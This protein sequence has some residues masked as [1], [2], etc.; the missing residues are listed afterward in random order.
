[1][2]DLRFAALPGSIA[3]LL[4]KIHSVLLSPGFAKDT[5]SAS[6]WKRLESSLASISYVIH[7]A[8]EPRCNSHGVYA[9][10]LRLEYAVYDAEDSVDDILFEPARLEVEAIARNLKYQALRCRDEFFSSLRLV[11][12]LDEKPIWIN[13]NLVED[14]DVIAKEMDKYGFIKRETRDELRLSD[15]LPATSLL[16]ETAIYGREEDRSNIV[17]LLLSGDE[18]LDAIALVGTGGL[19]KTTLA[20]LVYNDEKVRAHFELKAWVGVHTDFEVDRITRIILKAPTFCSIEGD[21]SLELLLDKLSASLDGKKFLLVLDDVR[22]EDINKWNDLETSLKSGARGSKII[23]TT[24]SQGVADCLGCSIRYQLNPLTEDSCRSLLAKSAYAGRDRS[25]IAML[26]DIGMKIL[27]TCGGIPL[28]VRVIGGLL[29]F[30]KSREEWCHVLE[31]LR[32]A[33]NHDSISSIVL[34]SYYHLPALLKLC[35]AYCSLFPIDYEFHKEE[36]VLLWMAAGFLQMSSGQSMET[37]GAE[38]VDGL[39]KRSF[40]IPIDNSHFKMHDLIHCFAEDVS[41]ELCLRWESS[42]QAA[43]PQRIRHL[44]LLRNE[45]DIPEMLSVVLHW[46]R[47]RTF[48]LID[49]RSCQISPQALKDIFPRIRRLRVLS[50][51]HFPHAKLPHSI[52]KLKYLHYLDVSHSALASLPESLS[53]LYFLQTLILTN[54]YSLLMLPQG[55][56]KLVNLRK[57][58]IKGAGLMQMPKKMSRLTSLQSLTNFIVGHGGSSIKELGAL[59]NLHGSLSVSGLQNVS[60]PSDASGANLKAMLYL[61]ELE[62]EWSCNN[63]DPATDQKEVL[64]NLKP[65]VELKKLSIRFYG[66]KEFPK[67]LGDSSFSKIISLHLSDCINCKSFPPLGRLSSLEHL[68]I[69]RIG[70]IKS[71]GHEFYGVDVYG[72]KPFQSLKTLKFVEMSQWEEWILL[73]VDGQEFPCLEEFY[74]INCPLLKGDL[75][76]SLPALVKLEICNCEQLEAS[77]PQTSECCVPKLDNCDE[78]EKRSNDN[79]TAPSS[80]EDGNQQFSTSMGSIKDLHESLSISELQDVSSASHASEANL[81]AM[82][83]LDELELEKTPQDKT[84]PKIDGEI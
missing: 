64:E 11:L 74:V 84:L 81:E 55:I 70:G 42:D 61:D 82:Q 29:R 24:R 76:K 5:T 77:L 3:L 18:N 51:P 15:S 30:K 2:A 31:D 35:F 22:N 27:K 48:Y 28:S 45:R 50:L 44:S 72:C 6:L 80:R 10:L 41:K 9:W 14:I 38:C 57:L 13:G 1:M 19:G 69:E 4:D 58:G 25:E 65:S 56:V 16:D 43:N 39:L 34:L 17:G 71:I 21:M 7:D 73:E 59:P 62:L 12:S 33:N 37:V 54:C 40:F 36:L 26:E 46:N 47:L 23:V 32:K 68:I 20:Q 53:T 60:S 63:E 78:V 49:S 67:W 75:P 79:Q 52:G 66:G 83:Y 8:V